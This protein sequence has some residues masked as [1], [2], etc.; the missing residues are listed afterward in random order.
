MI[1][2]KDEAILAMGC[3]V[4]DFNDIDPVLL[5]D[6][7]VAIA[8]MRV[9]SSN[10]LLM[11]N[12]PI[13]ISGTGMINDFEFMMEVI[14]NLDINYSKDA[15]R[16]MLKDSVAVIVS[17]KMELE[18]INNPS[19]LKTLARELLTIYNEEVKARNEILDKKKQIIEEVEDFIE[20]EEMDS[21]PEDKTP[22][23]Y[24]KKG[25]GW[26]KDCHIG[27]GAKF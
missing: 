18:R 24:Q 4:V 19:T 2:E 22:P 25:M 16:N 26:Y 9:H 17:E 6:R 23:K 21:L 14:D 27:F 13:I 3:D 20:N 15:L 7:D 5:T 1:T 12:F 10:D 11:P 8:F